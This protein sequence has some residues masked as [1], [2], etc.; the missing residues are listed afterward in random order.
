LNFAAT[1]GAP[2]LFICRNNGYAISTPAN[3]QYAGLFRALVLSVWP[4]ASDFCLRDLTVVCHVLLQALL[5]LLKPQQT[6][7]S[8]ALHAASFS[9]QP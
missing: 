7:R 1:L 5:Q 4:L 6:L 3:E 9:S 8:T 2:C